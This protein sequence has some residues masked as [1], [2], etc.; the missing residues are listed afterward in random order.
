[1]TA[2]DLEAQLQAMTGLTLDDVETAFGESA[3]IAV[4]SDI[5]P[6]AIFSSA[7]G[8]SIPVGAK[9]RGDAAAIEEVFG[10]LSQSMGSE[11]AFLGTD[12]EGDHVAVGP[13]PDYRA[14]LLEDG[15]LGDSAVYQDV[16]RESDR[17]SAVLFVNFDAN[18]WL[19]GLLEGQQEAQDNV[20]PLSGLGMSS[21]VEDDTSHAVV[22][23][24]TD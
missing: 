9:I 18:D 22:R 15:N 12:A 24:T 8:S 17:A 10:K 6:Q 2:D 1:M 23:L 3:V 19:A 21:W 13:N 20:A 5:D 16:I 4:D 11:A 14:S 7:D